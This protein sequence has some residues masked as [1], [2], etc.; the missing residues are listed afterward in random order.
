MAGKKVTEK[1]KIEAKKVLAAGFQIY[2]ATDYTIN[3][4]KQVIID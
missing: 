1:K 2:W 4:N 3:N